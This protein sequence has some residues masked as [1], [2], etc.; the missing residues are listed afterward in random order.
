MYQSKYPRSVC[1]Q[2]QLLNP[3]TSAIPTSTA[4]TALPT[5]LTSNVGHAA[6]VPNMPE[7]A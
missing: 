7:H 4:C 1:Q 3:V 2:R 5:G 6:P